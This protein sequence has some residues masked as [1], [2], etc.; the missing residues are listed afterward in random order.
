MDHTHDDGII[1]LIENN[2]QLQLHIGIQ[3]S[4]EMRVPKKNLFSRSRSFN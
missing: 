1:M 4:R 2:L 3:E